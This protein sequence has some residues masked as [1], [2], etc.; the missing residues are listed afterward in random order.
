MNYGP[1]IK[2]PCLS[3]S[4]ADKLKDNNPNGTKIFLRSEKFDLAM[5]EELYQE[6]TDFDFLAAHKSKSDLLMT[7]YYNYD[8]LSVSYYNSATLPPSFDD[9]STKVMVTILPDGSLVKRRINRNEEFMTNTTRVA[10]TLM[11]SH[12]SP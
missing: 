6:R 12:T 9:Y 1:Q 7:H 3:I 8:E 4:F 10:Y 5:K 11:V 2:W